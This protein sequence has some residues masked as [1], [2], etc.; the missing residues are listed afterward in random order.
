MERVKSLQAPLDVRITSCKERKEKRVMTRAHL[1]LDAPKPLTLEGVVDMHA[2]IQGENGREA[3]YPSF[4]KIDIRYSA[5]VTQFVVY[6]SI[7]RRG[8][9]DSITPL[10]D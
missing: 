5:N 6:V 8:L 10:A 2:T 4:S 9:I 7:T 3:R 1:G